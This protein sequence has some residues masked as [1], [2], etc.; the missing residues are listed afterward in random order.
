MKLSTREAC[1]I[2]VMSAVIFIATFV[3]K[4]P[5]PLGYA[6]LGDAAIFLVILKFGRRA[7]I[8]SAA[9][10]SALADLIGGFA[11]WIL[12]TI[13]IKSV[14][15]EIFYRL[16]KVHFIMALSVSCLWMAIGYTIFGAI[17]YGSLEV[18]LTSLPGLLI[19]GLVN[20]AATIFISFSAWKFFKR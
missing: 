3:P 8:L 9:I 16:D 14:M 2:A 11:I 15:A 5:I 12:P 20:L 13:L 6:N 17:L 1:E 18:G 7:G 4:I 10:G 19:E